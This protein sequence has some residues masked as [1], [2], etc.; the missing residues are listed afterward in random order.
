[1][2]INSD[3]YLKYNNLDNKNKIMTRQ[4]RSGKMLSTFY[5]FFSL[6]AVFKSHK[7]INLNS[8]K[9]YRFVLL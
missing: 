9:I 4:I 1:M 8:G 6:S 5:D 7:V 3:M 2:F